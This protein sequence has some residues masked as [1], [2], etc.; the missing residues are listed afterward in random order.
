MAG[1]PV[2]FEAADRPARASI[3]FV[4]SHDGYTLDDLVSYEQKHNWSNGEENRDGHNHNLSRNWGI[5]GPTQ[6]EPIRLQRL[7]VKRCFLASLALSQGVPM[8]SHGDE[9]GRSQLGNNNAYCHDGPTTWIDW[10]LD[11]DKLETLEFTRRALAARRDL[12]LP[13]AE[14]LSA[15]RELVWISLDG[16]EMTQADWNRNRPEPF[17]LLWPVGT[18]PALA[19]FNS[20]SHTHLFEL[21]DTK[22]LGRWRQLL[23]TSSLRIRRIRGHALRLAPH[24]VMLLV[25]EP[26][27]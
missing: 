13:L 12:Q 10:N 27:S 3:N 5:E 11:P 6:S 1:S 16:S 22:S 20:D 26:A 17:G 2:I 21:P 19:V 14:G 18:G 23:N 7:R 25:F 9:L 4:T 15:N 24:S 8:L